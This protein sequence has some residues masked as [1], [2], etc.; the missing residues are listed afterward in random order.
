MVKLIK[1]NAPFN[2]KDYE[3]NLSNK[4]QF[5]AYF[6]EDII[7]KPNSRIALRNIQFS[8][9]NYD[10][11]VSGQGLKISLADNLDGSK[12]WKTLLITPRQ[13]KDNELNADLYT[14]INGMFFQTDC[15]LI[16]T[17]IYNRVMFQTGYTDKQLYHIDFKFVE[18][19]YNTNLTTSSNIT[20]NEETLIYSKTDNDG[21]WDYIDTG[22]LPLCLGTGTLN[23]TLTDDINING[24]AIG[25]IDKVVPS[26]ETVSDTD[27]F[28]KFYTENDTYWY[29][30]RGTG[31]VNTDVE[32]MMDDLMEIKIEKGF[33]RLT[34]TRNGEDD[35]ILIKQESIIYTYILNEDYTTPLPTNY[36]G[37]FGL[38]DEDSQMK[39]I[40]WTQNPY[41]SSNENGIVKTPT[42]TPHV[43][44]DSLSDAVPSTVSLDFLADFGRLLGYNQVYYEITGVS[45]S[46][47][48]D[49]TTTDTSLPD[50]FYV[51]LNNIRLSAYDYSSQLGKNNP[52]QQGR[53]KNIVANVTSFD[54]LTNYNLITYET[55]APTFIDMDNTQPVNLNTIEVTVYD[56]DNNIILLGLPDPDL[57]TTEN[58]CLLKLTLL[59]D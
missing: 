35:Y 48:G 18:D 24:V 6:N 21:A 47:V 7:I 38:K 50:G 12:N 41:Y 42:P 8:T 49:L 26:T 29:N 23:V 44:V 57:I 43:V 33:F 25:I 5:T 45:G 3:E 55:D 19:Y 53:R 16:R 15:P 14:F 36:Y 54:F 51:V 27:F 58:K 31:A 9:I 11:V 2:Q 10:D 34:V 1:L 28:V 22:N 20:Y 37:Y 17:G 32:C 13:Y 30:V 39:D 46:F 59:V 56:N 40:R 52:T 4:A